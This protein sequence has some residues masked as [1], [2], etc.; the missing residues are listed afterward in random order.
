MARKSIKILAIGNSFSDNAMKYLHPILHSLG[1]DDI[2]LGNLYIG[3]CSLKTHC[4]NAAHN[5][6]AYTYRKN[7]TGKFVNIE[8]VAMSTALADENWQFVTIQQASGV[9][10]VVDTYNQD[11][12]LLQQYVVDSLPSGS[13]QLAW[14]MTWA[15]QQDSIHPEFVNYHNNQNAMYQS[16]VHCVTSKI[17]TDNNFAKIIPAGTAIQ[18]LRTSYI[19]DTVTV[20]GYHL[21]GLGEFVAGLTWATALTGSDLNQLD[22]SKLP[23][24]F[25][26]YLDVAVESVS[27]AIARPFETTPSRFTTDPYKNIS[28]CNVKKITNIQYSNNG[29]CTLDVYLPNDMANFDTVV[30][31]HGGGFTSGTKDDDAHI[32]MATEIASR[33]VAFVSANYRMY[34]TAQFG[35]FY[36]DGAQAIKY[37]K[38][39]LH[40]WGGNGKIYVS[41]QSAGANIAMTLAFNEKYLANV[42]SAPSEI[43]GW[44]VESGQPT[45]HFAVL[46]NDKQNP[47]LELVDERAPIQHVSRNN[48]FD[49]MLLLAY[50]DDIPH[51]LEQNEKLYA[52]IKQCRP[53]AKIQL[54][55]L[56]GQHC[57]C[58]TTPYRNRYAYAD[59]LLDYL[60]SRSM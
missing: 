16:I 3:G 58:S 46:E 7:T 39:N 26:S 49:N 56:Y 33:G 38:D 45:V 14:H 11:I 18:N 53:N 36:C 6:P 21:D 51:R 47:Q 48:T 12:Q 27:N 29:E 40:T 23:Q 41:G 4:F 25:C 17:A 1:Y 44:I 52:K 32:A 59:I 57:V 34:P 19:G 60:A 28:R 2:V 5:S 13:Y 31:F 10:G 43:V 55:V 42:S 8:N 9:S 35:D 54:R 37:V 24:Q 22:K 30:H 20:D 15:Y 50:T